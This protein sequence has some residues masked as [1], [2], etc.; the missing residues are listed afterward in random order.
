[1]AAPPLFRLL[2][3]RASPTRILLLLVVVGL[4]YHFGGSD[5]TVHPN[6]TYSPSALASP[7]FYAAWSKEMLERAGSLIP[8]YK[9]EDQNK[10]PIYPALITMERRM[11]Q[12]RDG[13]AW[14]EGRNGRY[15]RFGNQLWG[16]GLNNQLQETFLNT[17]IAHEANRAYVFTPFTWNLNEDP[18]VPIEADSHLSS[19]GYKVR[20][21]RVPL[22]AYLNSPTTGAP[23][24]EGDTTPR[25]VSL[26]WWD[27]VCPEKDRLQVNT[28]QVNEMLGIDMSRDE[29][30][31]IVRKWSGYLKGLK[32][33][34]VNLLWGT[35]RI[36]DYDLVG[37]DR[38]ESIW[39]EYSKSPVLTHFDWSP[40]VH[41]GVEKNMDLFI[42]EEEKGRGRWANS[43]FF[44]KKKT[45]SDDEP[46][47]NIIPGLVTMHVRRGDYEGHC[48]WIAPWGEFNG[49]NKLSFL[50]DRWHPPWS[51]PTEPGE[52]RRLYA[53]ERCWID[54]PAIVDQL[55]R[56]RSDHKNVHH[57]KDNNNQ[58]KM[59]D[60][61]EPEELH[62]VFVS[63]NADD[64]W[65]E[66]L[67]EA[68]KGPKG[69]GWRVVT[70]RDLKLDW[71]QAGVDMAIDMEIAAR[72]EVFI[73]N[74]FS[75]MSSTVTRIR[76]VRGI[77][78]ANTRFW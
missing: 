14:P 6:T 28:T 75:S 46:K 49:W 26:E 16:V 11:P 54:I 43:R 78:V 10:P 34:C 35:P 31:E 2:R 42:P 71:Q 57:K 44:G 24:P 69:V 40:L 73:G 32:E 36:I 66:E 1:M 21:A 3:T 56:T 38:L 58:H 48:K 37:S 65:A 17:Y 13:L 63:T 27:H 67:R 22:T 7:S 33:S 29:G 23:W 39:A 4:I 20:P 25:A 77:P 70:S 18:F 53:Y 74:G 47:G 41:N 9:T 62:T 72:G 5:P 55:E 60:G 19:S 51:T 76:L 61:E 12:H 50:P 68:L 8:I 59:G 52:A 30:A 64:T 15:L 45:D